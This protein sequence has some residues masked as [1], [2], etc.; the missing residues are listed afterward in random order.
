MIEV[1]RPRN[2][3][4]AVIAVQAL[5]FLFDWL[6]TEH[7]ESPC[8]F[9][10][11]SR[12]PELSRFFERDNETARLRNKV[13][14]WLQDQGYLRL[15]EKRR[16][17]RRRDKEYSYAETRRAEA[18]LWSG[19]SGLLEPETVKR[20]RT[21]LAEHKPTELRYVVVRE[22]LFALFEE[23]YGL[24]NGC[25]AT[26]FAQS[27]R[28]PTSLAKVWVRNLVERELVRVVFVRGKQVV[29]ILCRK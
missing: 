1:T 5:G 8:G 17:G 2:P 4:D 6:G 9:E 29:K 22:G 16:P 13:L 18:A 12:V 15:E 21:V 14:V 19:W 23:H 26:E 11:L 28:L 3:E 27:H 7:F 10:E 25:T 20:Y 24:P